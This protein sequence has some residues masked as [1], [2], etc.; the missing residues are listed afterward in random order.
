VTF[1]GYEIAMTPFI[2]QATPQ[3]TA[4]TVG[5]ALALTS[6]KQPLI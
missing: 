4:L 5:E 3:Q 1:T 2:Q 6:K